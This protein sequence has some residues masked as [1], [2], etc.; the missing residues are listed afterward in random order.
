VVEKVYFMEIRTENSL[1]YE[2]MIHLFTI[3]DH[4]YIN[5]TQVQCWPVIVLR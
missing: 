5:V 4:Y 2:L 3:Y 1:F